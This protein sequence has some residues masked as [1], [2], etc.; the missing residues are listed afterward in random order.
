MNIHEWL[1]SNGERVLVSVE[2]G[3]IY[4][5]VD[6]VPNTETALAG[7]IGSFLNHGYF[8]DINNMSKSDKEAIVQKLSEIPKPNQPLAGILIV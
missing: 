1:A 4:A 6:A 7:D 2:G 8:Y 5:L 3:E